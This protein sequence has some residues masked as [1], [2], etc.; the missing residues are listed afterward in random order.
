MSFFIYFDHTEGK[1]CRVGPAATLTSD[2]CLYPFRLYD[3]DNDLVF[4][5][6]STKPDSFDPLDYAQAIYGVTR[7]DYCTDGKWAML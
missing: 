2:K 4:S 1:T 6:V 7:I 5:G 3:G